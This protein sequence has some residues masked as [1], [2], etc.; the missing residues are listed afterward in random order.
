M[1]AAYLMVNLTYP[2]TLHKY[3]CDTNQLCHGHRCWDVH[4]IAFP[5]IHQQIH[6]QRRTQQDDWGTEFIPYSVWFEDVP[7]DRRGSYLVRHARQWYPE[8]VNKEFR[9]VGRYRGRLLRG[10]SYMSGNKGFQ[11]STRCGINIAKHDFFLPD[12]FYHVWTLNHIVFWRV[13]QADSK[14]GSSLKLHLQ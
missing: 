13:L 7:S 3:S 6:Y 1:D 2:S 4:R 10:V 14:T 8:A 9:S 11:R 12:K 5:R